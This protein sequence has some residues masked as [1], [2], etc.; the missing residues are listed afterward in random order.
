MLSEVGRC[1]QY[2]SLRLINGV[3]NMI[4]V[5]GHDKLHVEMQRTYG[6]LLSVVK[7]PKSGGVRILLSTPFVN[8][9]LSSSGGGSRLC[10]PR[11]RA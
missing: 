3:V 4:L 10:I 5:V 11:T 6:S 1:L 9:N 7:V 8:S 2:W